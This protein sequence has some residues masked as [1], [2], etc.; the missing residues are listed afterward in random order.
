VVR[1]KFDWV[2]SRVNEMHGAGSWVGIDAGG[3]IEEVRARIEKAV[4]ELKGRERRGKESR[5]WVA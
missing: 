1:E 4:D 5:L 3:S 2:G